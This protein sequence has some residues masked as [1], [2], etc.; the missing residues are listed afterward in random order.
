MRI[1][2]GTTRIALIGKRYTLKI[3]KVYG[4]TLLDDIKVFSRKGRFTTVAKLHRLTLEGVKSNLWE[5][6]GSLRLGEIVVPTR[7]SFFGIFNIQDSASP[8]IGFSY[9]EFALILKEIKSAIVIAEGTEHT[10]F[11]QKNYG[12]HEGKIKLIDCGNK[13]LIQILMRSR[14]SFRKALDT[15][16]Q[17]RIQSSGD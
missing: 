10:I 17:L 12:F 11:S 16:Q 3:P 14:E 9:D 1:A 6:Y 4:K 2:K 5:F 15:I 13:N 8:I 7:F